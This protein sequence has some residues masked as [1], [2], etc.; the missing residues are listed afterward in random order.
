[1]MSKEVHCGFPNSGGGGGFSGEAF[2]EAGD[3][4]FGVGVGEPTDGG[5]E[6]VAFFGS[7]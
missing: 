6:K 4:E 3:Y 2:A 5:S 1:M 7:Q